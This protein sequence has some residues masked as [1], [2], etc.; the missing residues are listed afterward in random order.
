MRSDLVGRIKSEMN[1]SET[2]QYA[3]Q[4]KINETLDLLDTVHIPD[5]PKLLNN[6]V[7]LIGVTGAGT[8]TLS[9]FLAHNLKLKAIRNDPFGSL[10]I[11]DG[12]NK[13]DVSKTVPNTDILL[14]DFPGFSNTHSAHS[15]IAAAVFT[16]HLLDKSKNLKILVVAAY[17]SVQGRTIHKYKRFIKLL[18]HLVHFI[19]DIDKYK[20]SIG[21]VV[22][23]ADLKFRDD[24]N[25]KYLIKDDDRIFLIGKFLKEVKDKLMETPHS[26]GV[27]DQM[28]LLDILTA[29]DYSKIGIFSRPTKIGALDSDTQ[30]TAN[31]DAIKTIMKTVLTYSRVAPEDFVVSLPAD[32]KTLVSDLRETL[33]TRLSNILGEYIMVSQ[34]S[35]FYHADENIENMKTGISKSI[36]IV[37]LLESALIPK[38]VISNIMDRI[39]KLNSG[40]A[41]QQ[42]V[43]WMKNLNYL[44]NLESIDPTNKETGD[45]DKYSSRIASFR[46]WVSDEI[47]SMAR[48]A[49]KI[50]DRAIGE[51]ITEVMMG[52]KNKTVNLDRSS[53]LPYAELS[54]QIGIVNAS[55]YKFKDKYQNTPNLAFRELLAGFKASFNISN[56]HEVKLE[57]L[58]TDIDFFKSNVNAT[59]TDGHQAEWLQGFTEPLND[60]EKEANWLSFITDS[61]TKLIDYDIQKNITN[62]QRNLKNWTN[63]KDFRKKLRPNEALHSNLEARLTLSGKEQADLNNLI[64]ATDPSLVFTSNSTKLVVKGNVIKLSAVTPLFSSIFSEL[65]LFA[66]QTVFIDKSLT[67][68]MKNVYIIAP[69]WIIKGENRSID[70]RGL[71][72]HSKD[73]TPAGEPGQPGGNF[74]GIGFNFFNGKNLTINVSGGNGGKGE[75]GTNGQDGEDGLTPSTPRNTIWYKMRSNKLGTQEWRPDE[76][77]LEELR[78]QKLLS[79]MLNSHDYC[80]H[81]IEHEQIAGF[82][83]EGGGLFKMFGT[84]GTPGSP[85]GNGGKPGFGA[86]PGNILIHS[87]SDIGELAL[88]GENGAEGR[89][90]QGGRGGKHGETRNIQC[91]TVTH[92]ALFK[93]EY[94]TVSLKYQE[95]ADNGKNG[96]SGVTGNPVEPVKPNL[97]VPLSAVAE[98]YKQYV[99]PKKSRF[100]DSLGFIDRYVSNNR[101]RR[102]IYATCAVDNA[103]W[104]PQLLAIESGNMTNM[105]WPSE[106]SLSSFMTLADVLIRKKMK[107]KPTNVDSQVDL[108][109]ENLLVQADVLKMVE[110]CETRWMDLNRYQIEQTLF[111]PLCLQRELKGYFQKLMADKS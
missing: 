38:M 66:S 41:V 39:E 79:Q 32:S 34:K 10:S 15:D 37:E 44:K 20:D 17:D 25:S 11:A 99:Q 7:L 13:V 86:Q 52:V 110:K 108:A 23:K 109:W 96:V 36:A 87:N 1:N 24:S 4:A 83:N 8:S 68:P 89:G 28:K 48:K 107:I 82:A 56:I 75:D 61:Y 54:E 88:P 105:S 43:E 72:A 45:F 57:Y 18:G 94:I 5:E 59:L 12:N 30:L 71:D 69:I 67:E 101:K 103:D 85:G 93:F 95:S 84:K 73:P 46:D 102:S 27:S 81:R 70:L 9:Q 31:R 53:Q 29:K 65:Y 40:H 35:L 106:F 58:Q 77:R 16:K 92:N 100:I 111:D 19:K 60:I 6:V 80:E 26:N 74:I 76:L 98:Q 55:C 33:N 91:K 21:M 97:F 90:G 104:T 51:A 63:F 14:A 42:H 2:T 78:L 62:N 3:V 50:I 47:K 64:D 49:E 22:T